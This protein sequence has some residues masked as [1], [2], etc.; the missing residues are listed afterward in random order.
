MKILENGVYRAEPLSPQEK[1]R[2]N[3]ELRAKFEPYL[4]KSDKEHEQ[5]AYDLTWFQD[6]PT[7]FD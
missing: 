6:H 2:L 4:T 1:T 3:A 7:S 5:A